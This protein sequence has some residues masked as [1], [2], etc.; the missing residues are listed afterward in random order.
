MKMLKKMTCLALALIMLLTA[1]AVAEFTLGEGI[2]FT[3]M[4]IS[5]VELTAE[6]WISDFENRTMATVL[7]FVECGLILLEDS[8]E[9]LE[10]C[11]NNPS[12]IGRSGDTL[13]VH[14]HGDAGDIAVSYEVTTGLAEYMLVESFQ[15]S[16]IEAAMADA[17]PDGYYLN[18][19]DDIQA[20]A[21]A[22]QDYI[23]EL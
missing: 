10:G 19:V 11:L 21:R 5:N 20:A 18:D 8:S 22:F 17:C 12:Y 14:M 13:V 7:L 16:V 23:G 15:D 1:C 9:Y 2:P 3:P 6:E 4:I